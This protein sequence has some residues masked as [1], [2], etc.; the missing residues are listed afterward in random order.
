MTT[1]IGFIDDDVVR[2]KTGPAKRDRLT[3]FFGD[4]VEIVEA[5]RNSK[6]TTELIVHDQGAGPIHG[7][8]KG[9][10][11]TR[12]KGLLR[13]SMVDVQQGDGMI[14]ETPQGKIVFIDGGDNQ[15]FA[16]H[17]AARYRHRKSSKDKPLEVDAIIVTHGDADHFKGLNQIAKSE[18]D[19]R[20]A[21][22]K[23]LFIHPK[24]IFHN[25][26]VKASSTGR[27]DEELLG[28]T[29]PQEDGLAIVQLIDDPSKA[30]EVRPEDLNVPFKAWVKSIKRWKEHGPIKLKRIAFGDEKKRVFDFLNEENIKVE[31][32]GPFLDR[33]KDP[34]R[35]SR[36]V[37]ALPFLHEPDKSLEM[38]LDDEATVKPSFSASHTI[39]GHSIALRFTYGNVR[40]NLTGDLNNESMVRQN[41]RLRNKKK[42]R[43]E[44]V[45]APHHG[46]ADFNL[47]AL[48]RMAPVVSIISSGDESANKEHIHPRATLM[49]ALGRANRG[50]TGILFC[51][52]LAA[53]FAVKKYSHTRDDLRKFFKRQGDKT[54]TAKQLAKM[55]SGSGFKKSDQHDGPDYFFAFQRTNFGIIHIRTDGERV[56]VF[57]HSGKAGMHEA[58]RF[59]VDKRHRVKFA[60]RIKK[61]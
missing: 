44:I 54:Y 50:D 33:V 51:T 40:F 24:R 39:N 52:E 48:K 19:R 6:D 23:R 4:K 29:V 18:T 55:F 27:K 31:V 9:K 17:A 41:R 53:F 13:F 57:T 34:R 16:R 47:S 46:S 11:K 38:H 32:L 8:V 10:L 45:K 60:K 49:S 43:A 35:N 21:E 22:R 5:A 28:R 20:I 59:T 58:Y 14:L 2:V 61:R 30:S 37:D 1:Q 25:G 7:T 42:L 15:L 3:L 26:L 56:L 36:T 12:P